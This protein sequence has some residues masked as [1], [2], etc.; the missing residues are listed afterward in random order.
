MLHLVTH[1]YFFH[2]QEVKPQIRPGFFTWEMDKLT[3]SRIENPMIRSGIVLAGVNASLKEGRDDGLVSAQKILGL[4]LK[5]T[6]LVV[7]SAC[8]T[9]LGDIKSGEGVFGL[10]WAF[11]LSGAKTTEEDGD[12]E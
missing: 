6:E 4:R 9:A 11:I 8:N 10:K 1:G 3:A 7:A 5:G 12:D 2:M